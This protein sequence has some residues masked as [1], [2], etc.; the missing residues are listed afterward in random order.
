MD[1]TLPRARLGTVPVELKP[2][3]LYN[4][5]IRQYDGTSGAHLAGQEFASVAVGAALEVS[6][7][8]SDDCQ[9]VIARGKD[10]T[11][12]TALGTRTLQKVQEV[13]TADSTVISQI[14]PANQESMNKMP[15]VLHLEHVKVW[16]ISTPIPPVASRKR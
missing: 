6:L 2:D 11:V 3:V 10:K 14:D 9:L 13:I 1:M 8:A 4:L 15:Y 5:E 16:K 7:T 12:K